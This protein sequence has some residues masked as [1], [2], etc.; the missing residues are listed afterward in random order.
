MR[1]PPRAVRAAQPRPPISVRTFQVGRLGRRMTR[2]P[3]RSSG[4]GPCRV[5]PFVLSDDEFATYPLWWVLIMS[6]QVTEDPD[7]RLVGSALTATPAAFIAHS[8]CAH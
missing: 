1:G 7:P 5:R 2:P 4:R 3:R 8:V 6:E